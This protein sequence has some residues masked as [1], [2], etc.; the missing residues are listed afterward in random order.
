MRS[1]SQARGRRFCRV[2]VA[3][4]VTLFV[5]IGCEDEPEP[6]AAPLPTLSPA[7]SSPTA[8]QPQEPSQVPE[9]DVSGGGPLGGD[10]AAV[11][12]LKELLPTFTNAVQL[13]DSEALGYAEKVASFI[14][15][16]GQTFNAIKS[17]AQ[18]LL[19][20]G[21]VGARAYILP[22]RSMA[23]AVVIVSQG[24]LAQMPQ[25]AA[26]CLLATVLGGGPGSVWDPCARTYNFRA[27]STDGTIDHYFVLAVSTSSAG[28][29]DIAAFHHRFSPTPGF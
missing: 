1:S 12:R 15:A 22:D 20:N 8:S 29:E 19:D 6:T 28:C 23:S 16:V 4:L 26:Q 7:P 18:C 14:P 24:Q 11:A 2:G 10:P 9:P 25:I 5:A 21:V 13:D 27:Q 3:L 17:G